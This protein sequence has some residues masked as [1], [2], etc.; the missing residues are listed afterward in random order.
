MKRAFRCRVSKNGVF[1]PNSLPGFWTR[2]YPLIMPILTGFGANWRGPKNGQGELADLDALDYIRFYTVIQRQKKEVREAWQEK[3]R[4]NTM[5]IDDSHSFSV[6]LE[7]V[8]LFF[9]YLHCR[10]YDFDAA[11]KLLR[12]E[13]EALAYCDRLGAKVAKVKTQNQDHHQSS[14]AMVAT[15]SYIAGEYCLARKLTF[16]KTPD[17]R[18]VWLVNNQLHVTAR[19]LDGAIPSL[20]SPKLV[21]EIKEYW[22]KTS[23]GSKM[24]DAVYECAL[25]GRELREFEERSGASRV[26]HIVFIDGKEQWTSRKSDL[27]R[28]IDLFHQGMIDYLFIGREVEAEWQK[29][30]SSSFP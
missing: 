14:A 1:G 16:S 15:V 30:L 8:E 29:L 20:D 12:T 6:P 22:G 26:L 19:N 10:E 2:Q 21:W 17:R 28:F 27:K 13:E 11:M 3:L 7:H 4:H 24:S 9:D 18:C 23:G 25:V 5:E